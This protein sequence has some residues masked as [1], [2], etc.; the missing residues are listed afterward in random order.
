MQPETSGAGSRGLP[1]NILNS[2]NATVAT[3]TTDATGFYYY[4]ATGG[5]SSGS[6]YTVKVTV[7]KATRNSTPS[8]QSFAWKAVGVT[9]NNFVLN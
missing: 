2:K 4:A 6:S 9:R 5:L 3:A 1:V 7:P 8:S